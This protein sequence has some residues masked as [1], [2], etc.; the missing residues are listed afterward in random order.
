MSVN[1][2]RAGRAEAQHRKPVRSV[3]AGQPKGLVGS[4]GGLN[5]DDS[6]PQPAI[7]SS[8][9]YAASP[10][11]VAPSL[12]TNRSF[13]KSGNEQGNQSGINASS[14]ESSGAAIFHQNLVQNG[15]HPQIRSPGYSESPSPSPAATKPFIPRAPSQSA[16]S[17][18]PMPLPKGDASKTFTLQFGS[19]NPGV[20]GGLQFPARTSSAPPNLDEQNHNQAHTKSM[21]V[22]PSIS[23]PQIKRDVSVPAPSAT[24]VSALNSSGPPISRMPSPLHT[25]FQPQQTQ[26]LPKFGVPNVQMHQPGF[27]AN[28]LQMAMTLPM[29]NSPQ[30]PQQI[31]VPSIQPH[32]VQQ[33][34]M[35]HQGQALGFARSIGQLLPPQ[36]GN[37]RIGISP[38]F[39]Q[40]QPVKYGGARKTT[41]KITHPDTHE[42]LRLDKNTDLGKDGDLAGQRPQPNVIPQ[43]H[44][45]PTYTHQ[46]NF[47]PMQQNSYSHSQHIFPNSVPLG[48]G[49]MPTNSQA[50]RYNYP[51]NQIGLN[52]NFLDSSA[53]NHIPSG[54]SLS[55]PLHGISEGLKLEALSVSASLP[56]SG[57]VT[58]RPPVG[59]KTVKTGASLSSPSV[60]ITMPSTKVEPQM[61]VKTTADD[62]ALNERR[63]ETNPGGSSQQIKLTSSSSV[64]M[65]VPVTDINTTIPLN[66]RLFMLSEASLSP[67][68]PNRE[69]G[70][71][72]DGNHGEKNEHAQRCDTS[73]D[74]HGKT[75]KKDFRNTQQNHQLDASSK[76][77]KVAPK[78]ENRT[79]TETEVAEPV[80]DKVMPAASGSFPEIS[81]KEASLDA[82][83]GYGNLSSAAPDVLSN[84]ENLS[85]HASTSLDHVVGGI[86]TYC[87]T[88]NL[89]VGS[90]ALAV[91][92]EKRSEL[93]E[94]ES[95]EAA[96]D[97]LEDFS[98]AKVHSS[99]AVAIPS[100]FENI[101][102]LKQD[103]KQEKCL[104]GKSIK[105]DEV[106]SELL[107]SSG[108]DFAVLQE[109]KTQNQ[110]ITST[111]ASLNS[112]G[113]DTAVD[114]DILGARDAKDNL[115]TF[116]SKLK[117]KPIKDGLID[118]SGARME[119][120]LVPIPSV[121]VEHKQGAKVDLPSDRLTSSTILGQK[122]KPLLENTKPKVTAG[123][124]KNRREIFSKADAA[125][126][127]DLYTAYKGPEVN[128]EVVLKSE[129]SNSPTAAAN[130]TPIGCPTKDVVSSDEDLQNKAELDDWENAVDISTPKLKTLKHGQDA[131]EAR[132]QRDGDVCKATTW[133]YSRDFLMTLSQHFTQLPVD[134]DKSSDILD[135]LLIFSQG[136]SPLQSPRRINDRPSSRGDCRPVGLLDDDK[137][138]K[139][140]A[141]FGR[142]GNATINLRP[143]QGGSH[144]VLRDLPRQASGQ[145]GG[146]LSGP[147]QSPSS[148]GGT[149]RGNLD[150]ADRWQRARGLIPSS[151]TPL[152]IMHQA[153]K[154]YVVGKV[155]DEEEAK[156][157]QLKAILNKLTPQNFEK[158][159][160]LVEEVN[161][162]NLVTLTGIISQIFDKALME[163]TFCEM[164]ANFCFHLASA[165]PDFSEANEKITFKRLLLNKCQEEFERGEK[166]QAEANNVEEEGEVKQSKEERDAKR[167]QVRRR[168]LGNIR[169]I[170]ELYKKKMLTERI[171]HEC[172]KKLLGQY[173]NPDEED[174]EAL[175]KLMSTIGEMIDHPKAKEHMDVYFDMMAKLSTSQQLSSRVRF[176]L[177]DA[178]DLRKNKWQ[179]RRKIEGPKKIDEVHRDAVQERQAQSSRLSRGPVNSSVPR[180]GQ[181]ADYGSRG[182]APLSSSSYQQVGGHRALPLQVRG[183]GIQ[184]PQLEDRPQ[185]EGRN[186]SLPLQH[187]SNDDDSISLG[188]QG[189][190]A[191]GMSVRGHP[192][193]SHAPPPEISPNAGEQHRLSSG[194]NT[195]Y[196]VERSPGVTYD[197]LS[198]RDW[199]NQYCSGDVKISDHTFERSTTS[200]LPGGQLYGNSRSCLTA[201]SGTKA[202]SEDVLREKSISAIR[203]FYS[204]K[205]EKEVAL[206]I[207]ELNAPSFY[208]SMIS[209]WVT[210][211][212]ERNSNERDLLVKLIINLCKSRDCLLS[213]SQLLQGFGSVLA[214]LEDAVND[215]PR[216]A[217][218][219]GC[220]FA[221][222]ILEDV[223]ALREIARL[224][225]EGGEEPGQLREVGLAAEVL[226]NIFETIKLERGDSILNEIRVSSNLRFDDFLP[227]SPLKAKKLDAF[228]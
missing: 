47:S 128:H 6:A 228:L 172:I 132:K 2:S 76:G 169:L 121:S 110:Q 26:I 85:S 57:Q 68:T 166:E 93:T 183:Y 39:A 147:M 10:S 97:S 180:R 116:S 144:V 133:K 181:A 184:D 222:T 123:K 52:L 112:T 63:A 66:S 127:S 186:T 79:L 162:D 226:G 114:C 207:K 115:N 28:S 198:H 38:Q 218:F 54:K 215:A 73:K 16:S 60:V 18:A 221:K 49:Q 135:V 191:R 100:E 46:T 216:A 96:N 37:M 173:Q 113:S 124:K 125:C 212:F 194:T 163:P 109:S 44:S 209:I 195:I 55:T 185:F 58:L 81:G 15:A 95:S 161:I 14:S 120:V 170:G 178:I 155:S 103:D 25:Q 197:Q 105:Y 134:F 107:N 117:L 87:L 148:Q 7:H 56:S 23:V 214:S 225:L 119:T 219:L 217:E 142:D 61:P 8:S 90:T 168:M 171:M 59:S 27:A 137:W 129:S 182:S 131:G 106:E 156:Q 92:R 33:Q 193:I 154:K 167:L 1:Q 187:R 91:G 158:L 204:A 175:C 43:P 22:V 200:D 11:S 30:V 136:K 72:L 189:G 146:I 67:E 190:L 102:L 174:I 98:K 206:C 51:L 177:K 196:T 9:S 69:S 31:L 65:S 99:S 157:R 192:S 62:T 41:V 227:P 179:H 20:M 74:N 151:Q 153:E 4:G 150:A 24:Y 210:D 3:S 75:S 82:S 17:S 45:I 84:K 201:V 78:C 202:F 199:N 48:S 152:Q 164:Y 12:P 149:Q 53:I 94:N 42:E 223:A 139:S 64:S 36:L 111:D 188:P 5:G 86:P 70:S 34:A 130:I 32:F 138:T 205:D 143:G 13:K 101:T 213:Q 77:E 40:Q 19:I 21:R 118:C 122:N 29:G 126:A 108:G 71:L 211:S 220:I 165:L 203:E 140:H 35:M 104:K 88:V 176:M 80:V 50:P 89:R 145:L 160:T 159:F 224:I 83:V 208:P 141:S